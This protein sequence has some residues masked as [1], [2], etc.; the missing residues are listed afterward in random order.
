MLKKKKKNDNFEIFWKFEAVDSTYLQNLLGKNFFNILILL[1]QDA[2]ASRPRTLFTPNELPIKSIKK[3]F[4]YF[5]STKTLKAEISWLQLKNG[6]FCEFKEKYWTWKWVK[7]F[8]DS[9]MINICAGQKL[10]FFFSN[11]KHLVFLLVDFYFW[12]KHSTCTP[13]IFSNFGQ[14]RKC[15]KWCNSRVLHQIWCRWEFQI[16][17]KN[18]NL[19]DLLQKESSLGNAIFLF[20]KKHCFCN[21][22]IKQKTI[23]ANFQETFQTFIWGFE[24]DAILQKLRNVALFPIR[25]IN[26]QYF[27]F[28]WKVHLLANT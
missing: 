11:F 3:L 8:Y 24:F 18:F 17:S 28:F 1:N 4:Y 14:R 6:K 26:S 12:R 23:W 9:G 25:C 21:Y 13:S 19:M 20:V 5:F 7:I 15:W 16:F 10:L 27:M 22:F 2:N